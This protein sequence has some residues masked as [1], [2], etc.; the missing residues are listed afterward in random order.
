[1]R[2]LILIALLGLGCD[3]GGA[4]AEQEETDAA[5]VDAAAEDAAVEADAEVVDAA[6]PRVCST[7]L[8]YDPIEGVELHMWPDDLLTK[9]NPSTPTG[10]ELDVTAESAPWTST[11]PPAVRGAVASAKGLSGFGTLSGVV[12][13]FDAPMA[14]FP[15]TAEESL[16]S[17]T[18][19]LIDLEAEERVPYEVLP[20]DGDKTIVVQPLRPLRPKT[21][22]A[23]LTS[24]EDAEGNCVAPSPAMTALIEGSGTGP[25]ENM[26]TRIAEAIA[27][28]DIEPGELTSVTA[29]TTHGD[30]ELMAEVAATIRDL[31]PTWTEI[32]CDERRCEGTF[33]AA[34]FRAPEGRILGSDVVANYTLPVSVWLPEGEGPHPTLIVGHGIGGARG[35]AGGIFNAVADMG[36]AVVAADALKHGGHPTADPDAG[37]LAA[38]GFLGLDIQAL[39]IDASGLRGNFNQTNMDRLQL[40]ELLRHDPDVDGDGR[41]DFDLDRLGYWGISLGGMLGSGLLAL[42]N[43]IGAG[44]LSVAGGRLLIFVTDT[45][46]ISAFRP[47][48]NNLLGG[49]ARLHRLLPLAQSVVDA[50]DPAA[51]A[52]FIF[53][54]RLDGGDRSPNVLLPV[55]V[56]DETVPPASAK[57][58]ARAM[59]LPHVG[60]VADPVDYLEE[61]PAPVSGN[62]PGE[63]TGAYFQFDRVGVDSIQKAQHNNTPLSPEGRLQARHFLQTWM[64][65]SAEVLDPFEELGTAPFIDL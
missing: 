64:E 62:M 15:A 33:E 51:Y 1:M 8:I 57:A 34:D 4:T 55:A 58:L 30:L 44:I 24:L 53:E 26:N 38:L 14:G 7:T 2:S 50:A 45:G 39:E 28:A 16:A 27:A 43:D 18:L 49:E 29:W 11:L 48:L 56:E 32:D 41:P 6:P 63:A 9:E 52:P 12:L 60:P 31:E 46:Q 22:H 10:I 17:E 5:M 36:F 19:A 40:I 59:R 42:S 20:G 23:L 25:L 35:N 37:Q 61:Q 13:R 65:G 3:D 47:V 21:R 54:D